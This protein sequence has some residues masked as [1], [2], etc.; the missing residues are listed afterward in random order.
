MTETGTEI[1]KGGEESERR[2]IGSAYG[3]GR[4]TA[5]EGKG[6]NMKS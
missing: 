2:K 6:A 5:G 3:S 4:K 1:D